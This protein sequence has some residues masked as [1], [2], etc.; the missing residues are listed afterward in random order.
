[1]SSRPEGMGRCQRHG[2]KVGCWDMGGVGMFFVASFHSPQ[3]KFLL[4]GGQIPPEKGKF[5][6]KK[7]KISQKKGENSSEKGRKLFQKS[8]G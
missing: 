8:K 1:M 4:K 2:C 5:S 7:E 6:P 3:Q